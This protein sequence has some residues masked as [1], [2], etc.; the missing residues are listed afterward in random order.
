MEIK[1]CYQCEAFEHIPYT[2]GARQ[3]YCKL[4]EGYVFITQ[5]PCYW[6]RLGLSFEEMKEAKEEYERQ[7]KEV[8]MR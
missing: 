2:P 5:N 7:R 6:G 8:K 1:F 4:L 3:G